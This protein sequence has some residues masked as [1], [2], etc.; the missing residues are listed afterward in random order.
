[1]LSPEK[2]PVDKDTGKRPDYITGQPFP[3]IR[4]DDPD[5]GYKVLWNSVY[6]GLQRRQQ[7]QRD[8]A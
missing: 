1:M 5:A 7:P 2:Q 3:D 4:Q 8:A 6:A